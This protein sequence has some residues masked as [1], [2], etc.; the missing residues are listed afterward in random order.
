MMMGML[1]RWEELKRGIIMGGKWRV[2]VSYRFFTPMGGVLSYLKGEEG[3]VAISTVYCSNGC[4]KKSA[5]LSSTKHCFQIL[6]H[7]F[8]LN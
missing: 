3:M 7:Y 2:K 8:Y 5:A 1:Q 4:L 6:P